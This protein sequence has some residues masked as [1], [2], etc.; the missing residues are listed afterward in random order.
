MKRF[1]PAVLLTFAIA[2]CS[3]GTVVGVEPTIAVSFSRD[4]DD[5]EIRVM[6]RNLYIG[7]ST[8][9]VITAANTNPGCRPVRSRGG[10][11]GLPVHQL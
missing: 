6:T 4:S 10:V 5:A 3:D 1:L 7:A 11:R 8:T 2:G 9:E